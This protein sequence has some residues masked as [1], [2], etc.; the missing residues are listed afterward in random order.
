MLGTEEMSILAPAIEQ[1]NREGMIVVGALPADGFF[2]SGAWKHYDAVLAMY[3]D[4]GLVPF[5]TIAFDGGVNYTAG[6]PLV[7]TSPAHG[8]AYGLVGKL[9]ASCEPFRQAVYAAIQIYKARLR[10]D[11][12][13]ANALRPDELPLV[14]ENTER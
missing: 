11:T 10:T 4:Q 9:E 14:G 2:G 1:A 5:K 7:R 3:H 6:L 12:T 13:L 8:T